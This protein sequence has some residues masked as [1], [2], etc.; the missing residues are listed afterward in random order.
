MTCG[1]ESTYSG[2]DDT[3]SSACGTMVSMEARCLFPGPLG[4]VYELVRARVLALD[5]E[6]IEEFKK[7]QVSFGLARKFVWLTPLTKTKAL[8]I[9]DMAERHDDPILRN[10]IRYR[11][12]KFT[13]QI[14]VRTATDIDQVASLGWFEEAA[15]WGRMARPDSTAS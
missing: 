8:L 9:I 11:P 12:D 3:S 1:Q 5:D 6:V 10:V 7:T 14:E 2:V 4:P 15:E 13:H